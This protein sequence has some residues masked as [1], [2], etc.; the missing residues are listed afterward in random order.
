MPPCPRNAWVSYLRVSTP[1][2]AE[3]ELSL[4]AQ[5]DAVQTFAK[6]HNACIT[7]EYVEPGS[8]GKNPHRPAFRRML[9]DVFAPNS[10]VG[11]IV[12]HHTSRFTRDATQARIVKSKLAKMGVD[13]LSVCQDLHKDP[14]GK[15][16]EGV[17]ECIDQYE[18]EINGVRTAAAMREAVKQ[19]FF[20]GSTAPYGFR[21]VPVEIRAGITRHQLVPCEPEAEVVREIFRLYI[22]QNGAKAVARLLNQR[23]LRYRTGAFWR[24]QLVINVLEQ[25]AVA[26]IYKWGRHKDRPMK[27]NSRSESLDLAV[28]RIVDPDVYELARRLRSERDP[29]KYGGRGASPEHVFS[30]LIRCGKCGATYQTETSG[31]CIDDGIYRYCYYNCRTACRVGKEQCSGFRISTVDL[32]AAVLN[33]IAKSVCT[34]ER[35]RHLLK[36]LRIKK[37]KHDTEVQEIV[38]LW[39]SLITANVSIGRSYVHHLV[40]KINVHEKSIEVVARERTGCV[41]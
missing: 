24:S 35:A 38:S 32:D 11:T 15:L 23:G 16:M 18:S 6:R 1:E 22:S 30:G 40:A 2:Q 26:G 37:A 17:F 14:M 41:T 21:T 34:P 5:R 13:V 29:K 31:K 19:G 9:E 27:R 10:D 3:R 36:H 39:H 4:P 28:Q 33:H 20:P 8:S 25:P 12:V 7:S